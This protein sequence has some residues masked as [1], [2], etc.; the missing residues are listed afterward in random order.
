MNQLLVDR[1][2]IQRQKFLDFHTDA[3][4]VRG[5]NMRLDLSS[6]AGG[7]VAVQYNDSV[8][9]GAVGTN[10]DIGSSYWISPGKEL[11]VLLA[12]AKSGGG[13]PMMVRVSQWHL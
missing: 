5:A 2:G 12:W 9:A 13:N 1:Y 4:Q 8:S 10:S 11:T 3:G 7:M 6:Y